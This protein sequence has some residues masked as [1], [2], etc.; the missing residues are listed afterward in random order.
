MSLREKRS[1]P[2][3]EIA[4]SSPRSL[5]PT[6]I[7]E[8]GL[9]AKTGDGALV[10][11]ALRSI[12]TVVLV[13][14]TAFPAHA[15]Q[16]RGPVIVPRN[17]A[18]PSI[19]E[20]PSNV[21]SPGYKP[22]VYPL[23]GV[24][25]ASYDWTSGL[26]RAI[27]SIFQPFRADPTY[28][29]F[30]TGQFPGFDFWK[31]VGTS[32]NRNL[33]RLFPGA[34]G[35]GGKNITDVP[36]LGEACGLNPGD[37]WW[38]GFPRLGNVE[39]PPPFQ[40]PF[41]ESNL[42]CFCRCNENIECPLPGPYWHPNWG[43]P[44]VNR[45]VYPTCQECFGTGQIRKHDRYVGTDHGTFPGYPRGDPMDSGY[46]ECLRQSVESYARSGPGGQPQAPDLYGL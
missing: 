9:L 39:T 40:E 6:A 29:G 22:V 33:S 3:D 16:Q 44:E 18:D 21:R 27:G 23:L 7:G 32:F 19:H 25:P 42:D 46:Q 36:Q 13:A 38:I 28:L 41:F 31:G 20:G 4:S 30:K 11:Y 17:P 5:S 12:T 15:Q 26:A 37:P 8:R 10:R 34:K 14:A 24:L 43:G 2:R 45:N 35:I 1:N